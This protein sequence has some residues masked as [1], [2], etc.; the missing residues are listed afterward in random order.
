[1]QIRL[2]ATS[3]ADFLSC[4]NKFRLKYLAG[5][6]PVAEADSLRTGSAYHKCHEIYSNTNDPTQVVA[7]LNQRYEVC[8]PGKD[9]DDWGRE[10]E[11]VFSLF[12]CYLDYW[13]SEPLTVVSSEQK[14]ELP[15]IHPMT[16]MAIPAD[17]VVLTGRIDKIVEH[18][19]KQCVLELKTT[20]DSVESDSD[21]WRAWRTSIQASMYA[22]AF[23][24]RYG[25]DDAGNTLVDVVRKPRHRLKK[26]ETVEEYGTRLREAIMTGPDIYFARREIA[27]TDQEL[28]QFDKMVYDIYRAIAAFTQKG[29][30]YDNPQSCRNPYPCAYVPLCYSCGADAACAADEAPAGFVK[31]A[32]Y[33]K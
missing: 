25:I 12:S 2:S 8:P 18:K 17:Q 20:S 14:F 26:G 10:R 9:L 29:I 4:P 5:I 15:L 33:G 16:G 11:T 28:K 19:G 24:R 22:V 21:Y 6:A 1:M 7:Y 30:W 32:I 13:K 3:I 27:R 23:R 31:L